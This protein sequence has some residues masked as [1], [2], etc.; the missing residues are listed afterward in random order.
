MFEGLQKAEGLLRRSVEAL[1]PEVLEPDFA[2]RLVEIFSRIERL[3]AAGKSLAARRVASS[4]IWRESGERSP[5]HW[6]ARSTG[7]SVGHAVAVLETAERIGELPGTNDALRDGKLSEVQAIHIASAASA[8]PSHEAELLVAAERDGVA[9]L[10]ERRAQVKAA[11]TDEAARH[12]AVHRRRQLRHW[13]DPEGAFRLDGRLTPESGAVVLAAL[14]P[15]KERIFI[16]ARKEGRRE[17]YDAYAADALVEMAKHV[18]RCTEE[19]SGSRPSAMVHVRVDHA[20]LVRGR[21]GEGE[22]CEI[23]GVG[24]V[25]VAGARALA[26]DAILSAVLAEGAEVRSVAHL[27]RTIPA[28]VRTALEERDPTCVVPGCNER[29]HLEIDHIVPFAEGGHTSLDNLARLCTWHHSQKTHHGYRLSGR[30]GH[31]LWEPPKM[32]VGSRTQRR[33]PQRVAVRE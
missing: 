28:R 3:G 16:R 32:P 2:A 30:P 22:T 24:P 26:S 6:M 9:G 19:P 5:A 20:A 33:K 23:P 12:E 7:T 18:R 21:L 13:T 1:D 11:A 14:E 31:W 15:Y 25:S 29:R 27:G 10:K 4:G 8:S 17:S